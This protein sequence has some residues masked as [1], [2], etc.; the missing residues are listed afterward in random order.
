MS[1]DVRDIFAELHDGWSNRETYTAY[2]HLT[3]DEGLVRT[4]SRT[5]ELAAIVEGGMNAGK[6]GRILAELLEQHLAE[7]D[8]ARLEDECRAIRDDVGSLWRVDW[9]EV[10]AAF[11][12][13][14]RIAA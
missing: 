3:A 13:D 5:I 11:L 2:L 7:L 8:D 10:G 12:G 1:A 9:T 14:E 6:A 4:G